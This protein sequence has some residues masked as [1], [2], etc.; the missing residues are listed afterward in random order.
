M[1]RISCHTTLREAVRIESEILQ[2]DDIT[3]NW[4][5]EIS[6][7][8]AKIWEWIRMMMLGSN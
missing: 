1:G 4:Q 8:S 7:S 3:K 6:I 2:K 5:K